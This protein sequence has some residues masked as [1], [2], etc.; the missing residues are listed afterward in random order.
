MKKE[1]FP[2]SILSITKHAQTDMNLDYPNLF[3]DQ[4]T[5]YNLIITS[6]E[7]KDKTELIMF[8]LNKQYVQILLRVMEM[9]N[10]LMETNFSNNFIRNFYKHEIIPQKR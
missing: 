7:I 4:W 1:I 9:R 3:T 2:R 10:V 5:S 8:N 6:I